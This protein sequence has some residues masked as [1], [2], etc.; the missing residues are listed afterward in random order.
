MT[1]LN[2]FYR[3]KPK[4]RVPKTSATS[5]RE[6]VSPLECESVEE[7]L[8]SIKMER[9]KENFQKEGR[10]SIQSCFDLTSEDLARYIST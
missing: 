10:S 5:L 9:Y 4:P 8:V 2:V 3:P 7:W 6:A 1:V